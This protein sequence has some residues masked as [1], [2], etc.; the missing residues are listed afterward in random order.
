MSLRDFYFREVRYF[1]S[2][3]ILLVIALIVHA[4]LRRDPG[5]GFGAFLVGELNNI[6]S[7]PLLA[8]LLV[9]K[10]PWVHYAVIAFTMAMVG[11]SYLITTISA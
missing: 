2:L 11:S 1:W 10:R 7:L 6:I 5:A 3:Q 4:F 9:T 8:L